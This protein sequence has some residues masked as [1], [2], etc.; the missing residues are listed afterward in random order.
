PAGGHA[1]EREARSDG[2]GPVQRPAGVR[3][4]RAA[5]PDGRAAQH[6]GDQHRRQP[7]GDRRAESRRR[8]RDQQLRSPAGR[9]ED[10]ERAPM[11]PSR[12]FILRPVA[13]ILLMV[14]I[15]LVGYVA[16]RELPI[17]ALPEVNY[18]TIQ[19]QTLYPG[20]SPD[21]MSSTVTG[22]L[23]KQFGQIQGLSQM[24]STSSGGASV[25]VLQF[26][27]AIDIDVAEQ[28]VQ[29]AI[30]SASSFLPTD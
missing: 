8:R 25:I 28:E 14:A 29:A 2:G 13:T 16:F 12:P 19:I 5:E 21:V 1:A 18:P 26:D 20:A 3:L 15:L 23:E 24:T 22:P 30:N 4:L 9:R 27:L 7:G 17:S 11:S 10:P 6:H